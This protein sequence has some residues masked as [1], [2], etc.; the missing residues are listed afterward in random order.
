[1]FERFTDRAR[2]VIVMAQNDARDFGHWGIQP[3]HILL[4]LCEEGEGVAARAMTSVGTDPLALRSAVESAFDVTV[5]RKQVERLPFT[6]KAKKVLE[7]SLRE[8]LQLGHSY[9]GTEHLLLGV[10]RLK[11]SDD[12]DDDDVF[13]L[14]VNRLRKAV[15]AAVSGS[16]GR[17]DRLSPALARAMDA[18]RSQAGHEAATT[19]HLLAAIVDDPQSQA[20][21]ALASVGASPDAVR[22]ALAEVPINDTSDAAPHV[23]IELRVAGRTIRVADAAIA[24]RLSSAT[25]EEVVEALRRVGD[26][27]PEDLAGPVTGV[28][29]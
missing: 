20:A 26:E 3:A 8:A 29:S 2:R 16:S 24:E 11:N 25:P 28:T 23:V 19:G 13:G 22:R 15:L 7:L 18:G 21:R 17:N 4:A 6:P 9:I 5:E 14:P 1:M 27:P 12:P 10:L